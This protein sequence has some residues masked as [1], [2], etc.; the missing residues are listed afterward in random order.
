[1]IGQPVPNWAAPY[2]PVCGPL[3]P[4]PGVFLLKQNVRAKNG[5]LQQIP[6]CWQYM[7]VQR[8]IKH[9]EWPQET[10]DLKGVE[11]TRI[12]VSMMNI[13]LSKVPQCTPY[14]ECKK[15]G[16]IISYQRRPGEGVTVFSICSLKNGSMAQNTSKTPHE[17][18]QYTLS[19]MIYSKQEMH[20][21]N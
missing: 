21:C 2:V 4:L 18:L 15:K 17:D 14:D 6:L 9:Q 5:S 11:Q 7:I 3:C 19:C 13:R 10:Y 8:C 16:D 20:E 12:Y 1:M